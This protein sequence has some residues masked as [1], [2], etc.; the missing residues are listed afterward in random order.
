MIH[1]LHALPDSGIGGAGKLLEALLAYTD[2]SRFRVTA[3]FPRG[4]VLNQLLPP[5]TRAAKLH[6]VNTIA[7]LIKPKLPKGSFTA[8][9]QAVSFP[10]KKAVSRARKRL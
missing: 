10:V 8:L 6:S 2:S 3:V 4:F 1:I 5:S 7:F 9:L